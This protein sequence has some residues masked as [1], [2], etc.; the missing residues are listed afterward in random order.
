LC[1]TDFCNFLGVCMGFWI[2][3]GEYLP[4]FFG[5]SDCYSKE[6]EPQVGPWTMTSTSVNY[7][8]SIICCHITYFT[9]S[10]AR[11]TASLSVSFFLPGLFCFCLYGLCLNGLDGLDGLDGLG[12]CFVDL[13][14]GLCFVFWIICSVLKLLLY[15]LN[16]TL[17]TLLNN[18][19]LKDHELQVNTDTPLVWISPSRSDS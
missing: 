9:T 3:V 16:H 12:L 15:Y 8:Q 1:S 17:I 6:F 13:G 5:V 10:F 2:G 18:Y 19:I 11:K 4:Y 7:V 14:L